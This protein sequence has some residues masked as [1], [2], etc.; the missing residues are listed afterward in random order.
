MK[1][2]LAL[3]HKGNSYTNITMKNVEHQPVIAAMRELGR[4]AFVSSVV[5]DIVLVYDS[6]TENNPA[7][8]PELAR[9]LSQRLRSPAISVLVL[10]DDLLVYHLFVEGD[11]VDTRRFQPECSRTELLA[12]A[13]NSAEKLAA[14]F[15]RVESTTEIEGPLQADCRYASD[16]HYGICDALGIPTTPGMFGYAYI[17][18]GEASEYQ[19]LVH[20]GS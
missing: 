15:G 9:E 13:K 8:L 11:L 19:H 10:N 2:V 20:V 1:S 6:E 12:T 4:T 3:P 18:A 7:T 5:N 17:K 14:A 16:R